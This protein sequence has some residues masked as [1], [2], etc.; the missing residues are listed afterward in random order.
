VAALRLETKTQSATVGA[1]PSEIKTLVNRKVRIKMDRREM[2]KRSM[3]GGLLLTEG[4][5]ILG[6]IDSTNSAIEKG[7]EGMIAP[8]SAK[9]GALAVAF[10]P[11]AG[12][13]DF[14]LRR[15]N[16]NPRG[17]IASDGALIYF[18][19]PSERGDAR[20]YIKTGEGLD[21]N[22]I[23]FRIRMGRPEAPY[24]LRWRRGDYYLYTPPGALVK[25]ATA[26]IKTDEPDSHIQALSDMRMA[27]LIN[28]AFF[29]NGQ[30]IMDRLAELDD[31][32]RRTPDGFTR[33]WSEYKELLTQSR[34]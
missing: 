16:Q 24:Y 8:K 9:P 17:L 21:L 4:V 2:L 15:D 11:V 7:E 13:R 33:F 20:G 32:I 1:L 18:V 14:P 31:K 27:V 30:D 22:R 26:L 5:S 3:F 23:V 28:L 19:W 6:A 10:G 34:R 25:R 29:G 12:S